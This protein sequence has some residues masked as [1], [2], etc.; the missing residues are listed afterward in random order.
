MNVMCKDAVELVNF[1]VTLHLAHLLKS[2]ILHLYH[3][4]YHYNVVLCIILTI[5]R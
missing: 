5:W 3:Y 4:H 1:F 2:S